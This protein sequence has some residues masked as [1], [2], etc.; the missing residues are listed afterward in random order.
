M[1]TLELKIPPPAVALFL[2]L[3]AW[4]TS[5]FT[6]P[7]QNAPLLGTSVAIAVAV[8]GVAV[9]LAAVLD[10]RRAR[11]STN[12]RKPEASSSLVTGGVYRMTRNPMYVGVAL[13][14]V[15]WS[16][17]LAA[18]WSLFAP[19]AFVAYITRFQILPE[20]RALAALF[21]D[22]YARY[23]AKVRRWI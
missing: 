20:E 6:A 17:F 23:Q 12:P 18:P 11:T 7:I 15:A 22:A 3:A 14:L 4:V 9:S 2:G 13:V 16:V 5:L 8:I 21:G 10:F 19:V 1:V